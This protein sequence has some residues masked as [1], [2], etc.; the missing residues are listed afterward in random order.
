MDNF[1][2]SMERIFRLNL[3]DKV[4]AALSLTRINIVPKH[5]VK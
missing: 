1:M 5:G 3:F 2:V 4:S